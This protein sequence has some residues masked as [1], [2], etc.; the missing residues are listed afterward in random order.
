MFDNHS[1]P[2]SH[3]GVDASHG[4]VQAE[5]AD[6]MQYDVASV[7]ERLRVHSVPSSFVTLCKETLE[8]TLE[9][10]ID[11]LR[12]LAQDAD[13]VDPAILEQEAKLE[14]MVKAAGDSDEPRQPEPTEPLSSKREQAMYAPLQRLFDF[15]RTFEDPGV[16]HGRSGPFH[17]RFVRQT[18][19][20]VPDQYHT[21]GFPRF[22]PDFSLL[23]E[24]APIRSRRW[25]DRDGFVEVKPSHKQ[26]PYPTDKK[27]SARRLLTQV[28]NY[29][30][31]Y[32][33]ARPFTVFSVSLM[34]FGCDF[35]VCIFD[36]GGGQLSR[37]FNMWQDLEMFIRV[38]RSMTRLLTDTELGR[39]PSV[40]FAAQLIRSP[41]STIDEQAFIINPIG[42]DRR[43][44]CT[45]GL[46]IWCS[47]SLF[48]RGTAVWRVRAIN[49]DNMLEGPIMIMKSAWRSIG[50]NSES[51]IYHSVKGEHPGLAKYIC[52][53][54]VVTRPGS[55]DILN[56]RS[57]RGAAAAI[58]PDDNK[59][60][61]RVITGT[62]G[63]PI[64]DYNNDREL[65]SGV[66]AALQ[67]HKFLYDQGILHRDISAGNILL[68]ED[69]AQQGT[70]G[71]LT[72]L[73]FARMA[74][75]HVEVRTQESV[76]APSGY[77][78]VPPKL[79]EPM[80]RTKTVYRTMRGAPITGTLQFMSRKLLEALQ[81]HENSF[82]T[83]ASDD[84]ES[85]LWVIAYAIYRRVI[86]A[87]VGTPEERDMLRKAFVRHFGAFSVSDISADR[88]VAGPITPLDRLE[89][90]RRYISPPLRDLLRKY[91]AVLVAVDLVA[92]PEPDSEPE[93]LEVSVKTSKEVGLTHASMIGAI[94]D[95]LR[96]L[97]EKPSRD[98][99]RPV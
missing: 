65:L 43:R 88:N 98:R 49:S 64:W 81:R 82:P 10:D 50:R 2:R 35:C 34:V 85:F 87:K 94:Q 18:S 92:K 61:H 29:A 99:Q 42:S 79:L 84:L 69:P 9:K 80:T 26:H 17:R 97:E 54:D 95:V 67:A 8:Q 71:F 83:D 55:P 23:Q 16:D 48:G 19:V 11:K 7:L 74:L 21:L 53:G 58:A 45:I 78:P 89:I 25:R 1:A 22:I 32:L 38:V 27:K 75:D 77:D 86:A 3:Y 36:R 20:P 13:S 33:S 60:L 56:I 57:L 40:T 76:E 51:F 30:R 39:D 72:D 52:G 68:A 90:L 91:R 96:R 73:E 4:V 37:R 6:K 66:L 47:L 5:L 15:I 59:I 63:R 46:P 28:A 44:W 12:T 70:A 41:Q 93:D 24:D 31:L 14:A 62:V